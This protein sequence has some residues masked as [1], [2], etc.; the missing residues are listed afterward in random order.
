ME[1]DY[2]DNCYDFIEHDYHIQSHHSNHDD[3]YDEI[4]YDYHDY[5]H[6][7]D[8]VCAYPLIR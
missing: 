1:Q 4:V 3:C 7:N 2:Y 6:Y 8:I 5:Y